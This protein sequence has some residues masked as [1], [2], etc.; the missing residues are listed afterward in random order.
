[1]TR[2]TTCPICGEKIVRV[3]NA[4]TRNSYFKCSNKECHFVLGENFTEEEFNLQGKALQSTCVGC[5]NPLTIANGPNGL[6]A[7]CFKCSCD[8][9]PTVFNGKTYPKWVNAQRNKTKEEIKSLIN[10]FKCEEDKFYDFEKYIAIE[11]SQESTPK[12]G[13]A[14]LSEKIKNYLMLD[15]KKP[16]GAQELSE[17]LNERPASIRTTLLFMRSLDILKIVGYKENPL[18]NHTILYQVEES[19]LKKLEVYS[20]EDGYNTI[21][22]FLMENSNKYGSKYK[23]R[24]ILAETLEKN[25]IM[26]SLFNSRKGICY[27]YP[28]SILRDTM[29]NIITGNSKKHTPAVRNKKEETASTLNSKVTPKHSFVKKEMKKEIINILKKD[30]SKPFTIRQI[31]EMTGAPVTYIGFIFQD[32]RKSRT[33][34][35]VGWDSN[36]TKVGPKS[37]EYQLIKSPLPA[38]RITTDNNSYLT[39]RQFYSKKLQGKRVLS[40]N[41]AIEIASKLPSIPVMINQRAY[42]GHSMSDLKEAFKEYIGESSSSK[43]RKRIKET[44]VE[45]K[46]AVMASNPIQKKSFF[47]TI[48]SWF[49]KEKV[50]S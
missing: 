42:A 38:M 28:E 16:V 7:R 11:D 20:K 27:G 31:A 49:K 44:P 29:E 4:V 47:G 15:V 14:T 3:T 40:L 10:S 26:P 37:V 1:M 18:G 35:I 2:P 30:T 41:R 46:A 50:Y 23:N 43:R 33:I 12:K 45:V 48:T 19:P 13:G 8:T 39:I 22:S 5:G 25:N 24:G 6:Y 32:M 9:R 17:K 36:S 34:K 21:S